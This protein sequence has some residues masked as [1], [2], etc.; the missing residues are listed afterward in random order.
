VTDEP[1]DVAVRLTGSLA[2]QLRSN[3]VNRVALRG[4]G[5]QIEQPRGVRRDPEQREA[6]ARA[7][8]DLYVDRVY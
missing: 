7:V 5:I 4:N 3:I 8:A 1:P 6:I 2:G